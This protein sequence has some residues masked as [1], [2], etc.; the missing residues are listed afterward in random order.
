VESSPLLFSHA[1]GLYLGDGGA[2]PCPIVAR[3]A[4][5]WFLSLS[6]DVFPHRRRG[7]PPTLPPPRAGWHLIACYSCPEDPVQCHKR[8]ENTE[9]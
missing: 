9:L 3:L 6:R 7:L 2:P 4:V 1:E 5:R 8:N